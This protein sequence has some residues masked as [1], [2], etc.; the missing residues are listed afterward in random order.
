MK[1]WSSSAHCSKVGESSSRV[2]VGKKRKSSP[3]PNEH[4]L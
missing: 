1:F 2:D 4:D 3:T